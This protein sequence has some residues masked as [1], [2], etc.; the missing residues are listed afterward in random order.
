MSA[1]AH[2]N[3]KVLFSIN[4]NYFKNLFLI[5]Y[6]FSQHSYFIDINNTIE[7][8]AVSIFVAGLTVICFNCSN[9]IITLIGVE[10]ILLAANINLLTS[11]VFFNDGLG[12]VYS[13]CVLTVSAA[14][15]AIG[16]G[17]LIVCYS[18]HQ[19]V[20]FRELNSLHD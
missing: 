15:T 10:L 16:I 18:V 3:S 8:L 9:L 6:L 13:L 12:F 20:D 19:K 1:K 11:A 2:L 4:F 7:L 17:L 5:P 14:E